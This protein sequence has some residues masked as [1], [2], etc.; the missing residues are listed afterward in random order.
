MSGDAKITVGSA[1]F[2]DLV[3]AD[4]TTL[5]LPTANG[6]ST[7]LSSFSEDAAPFGLKIS[8]AKTKL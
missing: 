4:Y 7:Y 1:C 6:A 8:W 5:F 3:Y 2:T